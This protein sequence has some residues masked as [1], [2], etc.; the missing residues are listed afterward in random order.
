[1]ANPREPFDPV[2]QLPQ[3][4]QCGLRA[5]TPVKQRIDVL[6]D[7]AQFPSMREATGDVQEPL[8]SGSSQVACDE[9]KAILEQVTDCLLNGC[10]CARQAARRFIFGRWSAAFQLRLGRGQALAL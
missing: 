7:R 1:M 3:L 10:A 8:A 6:H 4:A 2:T 9:Q 5:A